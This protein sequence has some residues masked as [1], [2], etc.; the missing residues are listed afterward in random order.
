MHFVDCGAEPAYLVKLRNS[1]PDPDWDTAKT[2]PIKDYLGEKFNNLCGYCERFCGGAENTDSSP[3]VDHFEPKGTKGTP[4]YRR[5]AFKWDNLVYACRRCNTKVKKDRFPAGEDL[6]AYQGRPDLTW[7][8][9]EIKRL[10]EKFGK[11]FLPISDKE[12]YVNPRDDTELAENFFAFNAAGDILPAEDLP[13]DRDE[14]KWS[15]AVRTIADLELNPKQERRRTD[16][17]RQR[18]EWWRR[19]KR[20]M[21]EY[22]DLAQMPKAERD[23]ELEKYFRKGFPFPTLVNWVLDHPD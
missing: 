1:Q 5:L 2:G 14:P 18:A 12:G 17:F 6:R 20:L 8:H 9:L 7:P 13:N 4:R 15:K 16:L 23:Q 21:L 10:V 11:P 19:A 3:S 22:P